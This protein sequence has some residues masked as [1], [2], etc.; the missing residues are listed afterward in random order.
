[1]VKTVSPGSIDAVFLYNP[2]AETPVNASNPLPVRPQRAEA[3]ARLLSAAAD[4]NATVVKAS[5]GVIYTIEGW[6]AAVITYLKLYDKATT[7]SDAD[8]PRRTILL[9]ANTRF[10]LDFPRGL[11]FAAGIGF[12]LTTGRADNDTNAV[13]ADAVLALNIDYT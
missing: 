10:A 5:S 6:N 12:R 4:V 7:P 8:T 2:D 3:T 11:L 1:M 13:A 9:P